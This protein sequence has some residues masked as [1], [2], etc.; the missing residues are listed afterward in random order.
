MGPEHWLYTIPLRLRSLF[1]WA[2]ADHELD[3]EL[4]DHLERKTQE[5]VAQGMTQEEA[6][7]RA[8][9]DLEG[10]E[11]TKEKCRDAR[12]V[13]V[14]ETALQD[15]RF[16][17]RMLR[18][19][20]GFT[21][22]A[23]LVMALG[24]G[25][26]AAMFSVVNAVLLRPLSFNEPDRIATLASLWKKSG[27]HGPVSAPDFRDWHDQS[28]AFEAMA[29]YENGDTA[30]RAGS[31]A[32]YAQVAMV[33]REFFRV[34]HVQPTVGRE[35]SA[36]ETKPGNG[37]AAMISSAF[38]VSQYGKP[39]KALGQTIRMSDRTLDVVGVLPPGFHFPNKTGIWFTANTVF[40]DNEFRS[41]HNYRVV[42]RLKPGV[43]LEQAQAQM[44]AVG[45][46]LEEK[47]PDSNADKSVAVTQMRDD[48]VSNFRLTL[49]VM[50]AAVGVVLLIAC[51]N[52]ASMLLA[53][54][55]GRSR[56]IAVRAALGAGRGRIARQLITES[57]VLALL[58]GA[59]G[60]LLAFWGERALVALAPTDVPRLSETSVDARVLAF[61][62]VISVL[63]SLLFGLAPALQVWRVDL[64]KSLKQATP[65]AASGV[66]AGRLRGALV[67]TEIAL[68]MI[69]LITAGLLLKSFV[70]LQ[71]VSLGFRPERVLVMET[72]FPASDLESQKRATLFYKELLR[73]IAAA[74]GVLD[75]GAV[76]TLPGHVESAGSY[77]IDQQTDLVN[78][79]HA[80][81][82]I[83]APGS[84]ATLG[85]PLIEGRDFDDRDT[86]DAPFSAIINQKLAADDFPG[87]DPI[88]HL[89]HWGMDTTDPMKIVG[90]VG[91][92][93]Q[94]GPASLPRP[95][96]FAAYQQH[97]G[98]STY[99][100]ILLRTALEPSALSETIRQK[101][102]S[103]SSDVPVK[104]TTM[105]AFVSENV[106]APRFR[107]LLLGVFAALAVALAMAGVYGVMS[108]VVGQRSNEIGLRMALGASRSAI[109][110]LILRQA[111]G[112]TGSGIVVGLL[113][114][115]AVTRLLQSMLFDVKTTDP[116]TYV[117]MIAALAAVA[118]AASYIPAHRATRVDPIVTLRYE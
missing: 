31:V 84:F 85:I 38:A 86:L 71:N 7:R 106:A 89:I 50:L 69:L 94:A 46:R 82:S 98:P 4:R 80:V 107:T 39:N 32:E 3:D 61:T 73:E 19:N 81:Y 18:K 78:P 75:C 63:A 110:R 79:P 83:V 92:V 15:I 40:R 24:I 55:V 87:Q 97:P 13:R 108:Y 70:A 30:V 47:Y 65:R 72:N 48:M 91:D 58:S 28:T 67:V 49:W 59:L 22:V 12:R 104:F 27:G 42:G 105:E 8:R 11:Q 109:L 64:N 99:L 100:S 21:S 56:E 41:G 26:N 5:Y 33:S 93:R 62:F 45:S 66:I 1:R 88:G 112:L 102:Q 90:V 25:A 52:L 14:I 36:D 6:H 114:A 53:K 54:A 16:G 118:L 9:L 44:T 103:L 68:S 17:M 10:I 57:L 34:F 115:A 20:L 101:A 76:R 111:L 60:V 95:E 117:V 29:C 77:W 37:G 116:L 35:F 113:S 2:K 43:T 23:V 74:P 51:A 96:I